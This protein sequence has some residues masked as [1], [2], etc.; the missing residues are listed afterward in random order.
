M[1]TSP[2]PAALTA[3]L[4]ASARSLMTLADSIP[5]VISLRISSALSDRGLS[6]VNIA[7]SLP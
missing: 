3:L 1:T 6:L 7:T 4:I 2:S 5:T